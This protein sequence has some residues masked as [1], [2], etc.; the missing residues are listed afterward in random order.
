MKK[1]L[2]TI[3]TTIML[4]M[5]LKA[6]T[7]LGLDNWT[8]C[9]YATNLEDPNGWTSF[10]T[11]NFALFGAMPQ[12]VFKISNNTAF[13]THAAMVETQKAPS[14]IQIP[15]PFRPFHNFDTIGL[16]C[17]GSIHTSPAPGMTFGQPIS[18]WRPAQL[19][20]SSKDSTM[21]GDSSYI[22]AYLTK[23]NPTHL[24]FPKL[25]TIASG[26]FAESGNSSGW[27]SHT[28]TMNYNSTSITP[29]SQQIFVSSSIYSRAG[30]K[31]G[32]KYYVDGFVWSG[33]NSTNDING[34]KS[35]VNYFPNPALNEINFTS[36]VNANFIEVSDI[37]GRMIGLYPM[38]NNKV[39]IQT[40][41]FTSGLYLYAVLNDKKEVVNRGK[42]E[43]SK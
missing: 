33:Y 32:S 38:Q 43:V 35:S 24:P 23:W 7:D 21:P 18:Y 29:D 2:L 9:Q 16:L 22:L 1:L 39:K 28:I 19:T 4:V 41:L 40:E 6:Q 3:A 37:T 12:S 42:F 13:G 15:N 10:N 26:S 11:A 27:T 5:G 34:E 36:S 20:F 17:L 8:A 14:S 30:A 31:I 25:D